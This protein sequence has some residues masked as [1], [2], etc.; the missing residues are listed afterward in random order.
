VQDRNVAIEVAINVIHKGIQYL[1]D[2][3][4][5]LRP[6][7]GRRVKQQRSEQH[8]QWNRDRET[9]ERKIGDCWM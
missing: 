6:L 4:L 5:Q 8:E 3:L 1:C 7:H 9:I 2:T